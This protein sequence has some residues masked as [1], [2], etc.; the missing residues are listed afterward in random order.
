MGVQEFNQTPQD[1]QSQESQ[2]S[3]SSSSTITDLQEDDASSPS[4]I[5]SPSSSMDGPLYELSELKTHLPI[6]RG[7]SKYYA[8]KSQ[9]FT[10]L[11]N[12]KA[13][14]DL[15]KKENPFNVKMKNCRSYADGL[16]GQPQQYMKRFCTPKHSI[17]KRNSSSSSFLSSMA[18]GNDL[19]SNC[20]RPPIP[21]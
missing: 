16:D 6:K 19:L 20:N 3:S 7:L 14:E 1:L 5:L 4:P 15:P 21:Y 8:G 9:S 10:S 13:V 17:S 11:A 12:V 18:G 2:D